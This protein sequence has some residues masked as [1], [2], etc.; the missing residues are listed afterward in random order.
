MRVAQFPSYQN[1]DTDDTNIQTTLQT[2]KVHSSESVLNKSSSG[3]GI[4]IPALTTFFVY[5]K[6]GALRARPAPARSQT[7][8][9]A[10][11]R[12]PRPPGNLKHLT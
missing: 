4:D 5:R 7:S 8:L 12:S 6:N 9:P 2:C 10:P 11:P 1:R 3:F